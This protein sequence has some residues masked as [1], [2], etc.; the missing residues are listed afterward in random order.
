VVAEG[1]EL[2]P[3]LT[4]DIAALEQLPE[5]ESVELGD[6]CCCGPVTCYCSCLLTLFL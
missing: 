4:Q 3:E 2:M 6:D 5:T 1:G